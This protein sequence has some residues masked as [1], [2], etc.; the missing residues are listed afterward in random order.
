MTD[1]RPIDAVALYEQIAAE[2]SSM[3]KQ[4]PG[5]IVSKIM[6]MVLQ[7]PTIGSTEAKEDV[8]DDRFDA[9]AAPWARKIRAAFPAAFV[10]MYNELILIPKAN[11]YIMLNQV[12]DEQDFKAA[13]LEDCSRNAFKGCS[14]KLRDEHLDGINKL[15][16]TK[17]SGSTTRSRR[18]GAMVKPNPWEND[19]MDTMW[20]FMQMGGLK[21]DYPALKEACMEL[22]QMMMQKTAGQRKDKPKDLSWDNLERVKVTIIC[23]AM[24]LVLSGEYEEA[25]A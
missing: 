19:M 20:A 18:P 13:V 21:A 17:F 16:E 5:I 2:V 14:G 4:P 10:N 11:T 25:G 6:A 12:R 8:L 1:K 23:E 22:R 9:L 15:L 7:A 24:A 3:L